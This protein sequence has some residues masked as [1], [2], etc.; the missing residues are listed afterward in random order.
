MSGKILKTRD[1][2]DWNT[3]VFDSFSLPA[4]VLKPNK[5]I[6][7]A[8]RS[9]LKKFNCEKDQVIGKTCHDFFYNSSE[10]CPVDRCPLAQVLADRLGH[11]VLTPVMTDTGEDKWDNRVFS[12]LLDE[13]G[14]VM[15]IVESIHDV[16]QVKVL[17]RELSGAREFSQKL[18]QSSTSAMIAAD[19]RGRILFMNRAA[20]ELIGYT[21]E[22]AQEKVTAKDLYLPGQAREVMKILRD[23]SF[24][25]RGKLPCTRVSLVNAGGEEIPVELTASIIYEGG[26]EVATMAVFN[27]LR[28]K[29]VNEERMRGILI[30]IARAEKMASLGQLAAG[31]AHEI[32]NP[33]TGIIFFAKMMLESLDKDDPRAKSM[34]CVFEDAKRCGKIV[35]NLLT[36]SRQTTAS[37]EIFHINTLIEH[38]LDLIRDRKL[39]MD[40][41]IVKDIPDEMM[42]IQGDRDQLGQVVINLVMN[43]VDAME[44]T[45]TLTLRARRNKPAKKAYIEISDTGRGIPTEDLSRIFDP[46]FTTK[47]AGKGTGLGLSTAYGIVKDNGGNIKVKET[48]PKGTTFV[49]E[50]PL[51]QAGNDHHT[52]SKRHSARREEPVGGNPGGGP[53][54][55]GD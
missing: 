16:T 22:E 28:E 45:G 41:R 35:K 15:Y 53:A 8:N 51:Y 7:D 50:L 32:N 43:A 2:N 21:L 17:E 25:G 12:P 33:L 11:S 20:E 54:R 48:S 13:A 47:E 23:E 1:E 4:L 27:D 10:P 37:K 31:V 24:G 19:R 26:K 5:V 55:G 34:E 40:I 49:V 6:V 29:L 44:Q 30:R 46:F 36:Y 18:I 42:L 38:S 3:L 39:F 14:E 9:I 52:P